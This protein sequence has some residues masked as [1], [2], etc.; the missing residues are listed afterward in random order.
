MQRSTPKLR[1]HILKVL[2]GAGIGIL[3]GVLALWGYQTI[4]SKAPAKKIASP[5]Y[6]GDVSAAGFDI[7]EDEYKRNIIYLNPPF[8][9]NL[10]DT[11]R[12]FVMRVTV[13]LEVDS[14]RVIDEWNKNQS[15][16]YAMKE[17]IL[18]IFRSKWYAELAV[19]DGIEK[20]K[21]E[22]KDAINKYTS[23]GKVLRVI[24]NEIVLGEFM[25]TAQQP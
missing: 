8:I 17:K 23:T 9:V 20:M 16:F 25:P 1:P 14:P 3:I 5:V 10:R 18:T 22:L 7:I 21:V 6:K 19:G 11:R 4:V 24:F 12:Q 15:A 2:S 13:W